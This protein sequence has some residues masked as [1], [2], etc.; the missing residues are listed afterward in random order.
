[1][2]KKALLVLP[3]WPTSGP[4][5][6]LTMSGMLR[7]LREVL[8]FAHNNGYTGIRRAATPTYS[9]DTH[10]FVPV[11]E[12]R[13]HKPVPTLGRLAV[14]AHSAGGAYLTAVN[15]TWKLTPWRHFKIDPLGRWCVHSSVV[16]AAGTR[17]RSRSLSR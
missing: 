2:G 3:V 4:G 8:H 5:T 14:A 10:K 6:L 13:V 17:P 12:L 7:L 11:P 1:M 9:I 16:P 15:G